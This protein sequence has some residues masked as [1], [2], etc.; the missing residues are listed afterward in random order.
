M[1]IFNLQKRNV[2]QKYNLIQKTFW[3]K[4]KSMR[5]RNFAQSFFQVLLSF[6]LSKFHS[7]FYSKCSFF[8]NHVTSKSVSVVEKWNKSKSA[9]NSLACENNKKQNF[10]GNN[11]HGRNAVQRQTT[12]TPSAAGYPLVRPFLYFDHFHIFDLFCTLTIF[13]SSTCSVLRPTD[14]TST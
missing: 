10:W 14:F 3:Q 1:M 13:I 5:N 12:F 7:K 8:S 6:W 2:S 4:W 11:P 9:V